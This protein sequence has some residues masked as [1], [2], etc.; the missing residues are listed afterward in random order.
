MCRARASRSRHAARMLGGAAPSIEGRERARAGRA[1]A[2]APT[3][4]GVCGHTRRSAATLDAGSVEAADREQDASLR[5]SDALRRRW[6]WTCLAD[7][8]RAASAGGGVSDRSPIGPR[9]PR[10]V[11]LSLS[12]PV[13]WADPNTAGSW[14]AASAG[15]FTGATGA[16][17]R[18]TARDTWTYRP[19]SLPAPR[20]RPAPNPRL[21]PGRSKPP[22]VEPAGTGFQAGPFC[23]RP[24]SV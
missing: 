14:N 6:R 22:Q 24:E 10:R 15:S 7:E 2:T 21:A 5:G 1:P 11:S 12:A 19:P 3:S 9:G 17:C 18:A 8:R 13:P 16:G 20:S 4:D 23:I